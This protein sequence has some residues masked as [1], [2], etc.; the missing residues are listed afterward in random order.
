MVSYLTGDALTWWRQ[1]C[2]KHGGL[3]SANSVHTRIDLDV[4]MD[5]LRSQFKDI[6]KDTTVRQRLF[7]LI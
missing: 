4:L 7:S 1:Y 6:N 5:E 3:H 2:M